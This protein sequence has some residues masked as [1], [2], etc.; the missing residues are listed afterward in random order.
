[1]AACARGLEIVLR[2]HGMGNLERQIDEL[3]TAIGRLQGEVSQ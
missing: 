1:L 2:I 3:E